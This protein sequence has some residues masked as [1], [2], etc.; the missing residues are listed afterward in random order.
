MNKPVSIKKI[1]EYD[2]AFYPSNRENKKYKAVV[3]KDSKKIGTYHFGDKRYEQYKDSVSNLYSKLNHND[4]E[5]R[6]LYR[7][8][9]KEGK[10]PS[11]AW[12]SWNYL[13]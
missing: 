2:V 3:Y 9:H 11:P 13:W 6:K 10:F 1:K 4:K 8:R 5:R 7:A 12:F